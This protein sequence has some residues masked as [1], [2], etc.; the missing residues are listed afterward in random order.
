MYIC[1]LSHRLKIDA[2]IVNS[3]TTRPTNGIFLERSPVH[4]PW[5]RIKQAEGAFG[6]LA[7]V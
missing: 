7:P 5:E 2:S 4:L 1:P 3:R 6:M